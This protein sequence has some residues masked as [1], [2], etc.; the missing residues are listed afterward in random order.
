MNA[1]EYRIRAALPEEG[2]TL[3]AVAVASKAHWGYDEVFMARFADVIAFEPARVAEHDVWVLEQA[4]RIAGFYSL[5]HH[6]EVAELDDLWLLP[7]F[8]GRGLGRLLFEHARERAAAQ[9]ARR[10]EWEAEPFAIGFYERM[11]AAPVRE[12]TSALGR[13]LKVFALNLEG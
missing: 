1:D 10:L 8:I 9:G 12:T 5:I 11:G 7:E 3:T 4:G 6:G 13:R 2:A